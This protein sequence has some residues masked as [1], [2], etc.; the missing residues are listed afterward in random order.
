MDAMEPGR[1]MRV[2]TGWDGEDASDC[3]EKAAWFSDGHAAVADYAMPANHAGCR[4]A[5]S[6]G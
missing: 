5:G 6:M 2:L 1:L 3:T 4:V